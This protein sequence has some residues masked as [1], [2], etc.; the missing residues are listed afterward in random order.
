MLGNSAIQQPIMIEA[1]DRACAAVREA[2]AGRLPVGVTLAL[3]EEKG[4]AEHVARKQAQVMLPWLRADGDYVGVQN[5]TWTEVGADGDLPVPAGVELTQMGYPYAP[6]SLA[7][8]V[9]TVAANTRKPIYVTENGVSTTDDARRIAFIDGALAG[10]GECLREGIDVRGY[11]HWS[12][13][14]NWEW[15]H[16]FE[17][18][19]G[20]VAVDRATFA[21]TPKPSAAHLGRIARA[22]WSAREIAGT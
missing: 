2:S 11:V 6:E 16:G 9:R 21:R 8:V 10:L 22:G 19:F 3:N 13:L 7:A 17:P 4:E 1:H 15:T 12:L 18:R 14:D 5:Y 20:L